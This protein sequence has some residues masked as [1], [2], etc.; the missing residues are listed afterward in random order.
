MRPSGS[1]PLTGPSLA[2]LRESILGSRRTLVVAIGVLAALLLLLDG[3]PV[4]AQGGGI[5][6]PA[7]PTATPSPSPTPSPT[8]ST[9]PPRVAVIVEARDF[10]SSTYY[11][12]SYHN[13]TINFDAFA[14]RSHI[15][16]KMAAAAPQAQMLLEG[17]NAD[18]ILRAHYTGDGDEIHGTFILVDAQG[19]VLLEDSGKTGMPFFSGDDMTVAAMKRAR[20]IAD[21]LM[22]KFAALVPKTVPAP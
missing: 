3:R 20:E 14:L 4:A 19:V 22:P 1:P 15:R 7:T 8:P 13:K 18:Y 10:H 17:P 16:G 6:A 11:S 2:P 9:R 5:G 21:K 12:G